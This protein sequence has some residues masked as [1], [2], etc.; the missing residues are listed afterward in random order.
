M[1]LPNFV[2]I[3]AA[4]CGTTSLHRLLGQHPEVFACPEKEPQYFALGDGARPEKGAVRDLAEYE[5]LFAGVRS[6]SAVGEA[7][8]QYLVSESAPRR[9]RERIPD[10]R[11][12]AILRDPAERAH[13][14]YQMWLRQGDEN[15]EIHAAFDAVLEGVDADPAA[16]RERRYL[17]HGFYRHH[18]SRWEACFGGEALAIVL[19]EDLARDPLPLLRD[20]FAFLGVDPDFE[21]ELGDRFNAGGM[22]RWRQLYRLADR[23]VWLKRR[24]PRRLG[25]ALKRSL[26]RAPPELP[27]EFRAR[28]VELYRDDVCWLEE[29]LGRDLGHWRKA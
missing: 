14:E 16:A 4:K 25:V 29:R 6:E 28:L 27:R 17:R 23:Q 15:A 19:L 1:T 22:P 18:L 26:L 2:I 10:A 13:S 24:L 20:L 12:I 11:L 5:S 3:G 8:P 9:M 21:P 7:S